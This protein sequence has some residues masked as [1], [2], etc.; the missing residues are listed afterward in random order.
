MIQHYNCEPD[1]VIIYVGTNDL[2]SSQNPVT[3]T[4]NIIDIAKNSVSPATRQS[5]W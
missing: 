2:G 4:K 5:E 1:R 3:V